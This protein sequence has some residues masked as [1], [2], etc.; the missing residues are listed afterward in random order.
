MFLTP[1]IFTTGGTKNN[2]NNNNVAVLRDFLAIQKKT[3]L[4]C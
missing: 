2:N 3:D 4:R 1:G